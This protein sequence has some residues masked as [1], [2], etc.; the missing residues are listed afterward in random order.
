[1]KKVLAVDDEHVQALNYLAYTYAESGENLDEALELAG[2][3]VSL[4]PNDAYI[5]DTLGWVMYKK[6]KYAEAVKTLEKAYSLKPGEAIIAE[7]LGDAYLRN[8]LQTKAM[9]MYQRAM[10]LSESANEKQKLNAKIV[11]IEKATMEAMVE[12]TVTKEKRAI[13]SEE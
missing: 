6:G 11:E 2:R 4:R 7:H 9:W 5:T 10:E 1:M 3:A 12:P 8:Q 13:S